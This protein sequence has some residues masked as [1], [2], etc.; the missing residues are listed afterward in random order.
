MGVVSLDSSG[1]LTDVWVS[2][3]LADTSYTVGTFRSNSAGFAVTESS[4]G[5]G[6]MTRADASVA[7]DGWDNIYTD[8]ATDGQSHQLLDMDVHNDMFYGCGSRIVEAPK[9]FIQSA[10]PTTGLALDM[11]EL[12]S[13]AFGWQ[14]EMW[15]IDVDASGIAVVGVD[16]GLDVGHIFTIDHASDPLD[17][18][19]WNNYN[20]YTHTTESTWMQGVCRNGDHIVAVGK[21]SQLNDGLVMESKDNGA[22]WTE[23]T[24]TTASV[25]NLWDCWVHDD[26]SF[27]VTGAGWVGVYTP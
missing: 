14:G 12:S 1:N 23:V 21:Y 5:Y 7:S 24:P 9:V 22:T 20:L 16:Q 2:G 27:V 26:G 13:G 6:L 8:W 10:A 4:T 18:A 15:A 11:V 25:P 17:S 19:N 3:T